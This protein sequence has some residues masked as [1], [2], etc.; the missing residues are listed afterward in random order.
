V[1]PRDEFVMMTD[2]VVGPNFEAAR[3][4]PAEPTAPNRSQTLRNQCKSRKIE[5]E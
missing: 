1:V 3:R 5:W 2:S 4:A